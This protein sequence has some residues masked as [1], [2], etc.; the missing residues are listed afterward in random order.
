MR[1]PSLLI[2]ELVDEAKDSLSD[3]LHSRAGTV[4]VRGKDRIKCRVILNA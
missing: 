4:R 3:Y 2:A 1:V